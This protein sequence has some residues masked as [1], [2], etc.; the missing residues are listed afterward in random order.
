MGYDVPQS[1]AN[2]VFMPLGDR[3]VPFAEG[4]A[5]VGVLLRA[6]GSDGVRITIGDPHE[7]DTFLKYASSAAPQ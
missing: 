7:N 2:F 6:Y 1:E 5:E 3:S 4:A